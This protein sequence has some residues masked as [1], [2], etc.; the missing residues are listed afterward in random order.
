YDRDGRA[1]L[2]VLRPDGVRLY[3]NEG[4]GRFKDATTAAKIAPFPNADT[5]VAFVDVDHDGDLDV[6]VGG[7]GTDGS[8][9]QTTGPAA[10]L[11]RRKSGDGPSGAATA[12]AKVGGTGGGAIAIVPTDFDNRRD[13]D[14]LVVN[15][16]GAPALLK[17]MRDGSFADAAA[18]VGLPKAGGFRA[19]AAADVNKDGFTDFFFA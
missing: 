8:A 1:D 18:S 5:T 4:D 6:F 14:L 3:H 15:D 10:T 16:E 9:G 12:E 19:V 17:N 13:I 7:H 11:V 2:L